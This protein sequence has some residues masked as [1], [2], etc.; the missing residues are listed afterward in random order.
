VQGKDPSVDTTQDVVDE[1]EDERFSEDNDIMSS[2]E[3]TFN[4]ATLEL[5]PAEIGRLED[6]DD[7]SLD[8]YFIPYCPSQ[9]IFFSITS[10]RNVDGL[11]LR[12]CS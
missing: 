10:M 1:S 4:M 7:V 3:N 2:A 5:P 12:A 6:I 11:V 8:M 9:K